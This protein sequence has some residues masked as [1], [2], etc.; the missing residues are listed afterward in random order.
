M[1]E[2][3]DGNKAII[4]T[5]MEEGPEALKI[6]EAIDAAGQKGGGESKTGGCSL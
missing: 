2:S 1:K 5:A 4:W 6:A 3:E